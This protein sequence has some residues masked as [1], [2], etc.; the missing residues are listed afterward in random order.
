MN[1]IGGDSTKLR[2]VNQ[3]LLL[4]ALRRAEDPTLAD[5]ARLTGLS[6]ATC[7]NIMPLMVESGEVA[8]LDERE[9]RGGRPA[10]RFRYN[11]SHTLV[12][13]VLAR[14]VRGR[15]HLEYFIADA[16]GTMLEKGSVAHDKVGI[17][18]VWDLA[19]RLVNGRSAVK[20]LAVSIPGV[21]KDGKVVLSDVRG[22]TG[23]DIE[24]VFA[25]DLGVKVVAENDMNFAAIGYA[26]AAAGKKEQS[27]VYMTFPSDANPGS[28]LV[29]NG[30]LIKGVS[31]FAGEVS[32]VPLG[33]SRDEQLERLGDGGWLR[34][35]IART[36]ASVTAVVNPGVVVLSGDAVSEDMLPSIHELCLAMVPAEHLP[37]LV[38]KSDSVGDCRVGMAAAALESVFG[39][40]RLVRNERTWCVDA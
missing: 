27:L 40:Y 13:G 31:N 17:A 10:R 7:A 16:A 15:D 25:F 12:A 2:Q 33:D 35:F 37:R 30:L 38:F 39:Q 3:A 19:R 20:A 26:R 4:E 28:G 34:R 8:Q 1:A 36:V 22:L 24:D 5:L 14:L 6:L 18:E 32:F 11:P 23:E 29:V 9:S 21:V